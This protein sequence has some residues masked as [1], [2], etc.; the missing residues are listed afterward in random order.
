MKGSQNMKIYH[1]SDHIINKPMYGVGKEDNDYGSGFYTTEDINKANEWA[2]LN[3]NDS[4]YTNKYEIDT[5]NLNILNLDEY[6]PLS[7]IAEII[8]HRGC[9]GEAA[10]TLG[11]IIVDKYKVDTGNADIIIGYRADDSYI[12]IVDAFLRNQISLDEVDNLFRKG[13]LGK[14]VFIKSKKAFNSLEFKGYDI[15]TNIQ[16]FGKD[17]IQARIDVSRFLNNRETQIMLNGYTPYGI[18]ARDTINN[19]CIYDKEYKY[20]YVDE[21]ISNSINNDKDVD[22]YE[23]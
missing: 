4:A 5:N 17:E 1:G 2:A 19:N 18:L 8:S 6:G 12:D 22:G 3:G 11:N 15:I 7:W 14:Q 20:T 16:E 23:R 10:Q 21:S 13:N 9:R